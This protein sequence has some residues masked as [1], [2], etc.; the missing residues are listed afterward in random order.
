MT[1][2]LLEARSLNCQYFIY[3]YVDES[4]KEIGSWWVLY[5]NKFL[6]GIRCGVLQGKEGRN[7]EEAG[8]FFMA[9]NPHDLELAG[10]IY[11]HGRGR[12]DKEP[13]QPRLEGL[14]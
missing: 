3:A 7:V 8:S 10:C 6:E 1:G 2:G 12:V 14:S 4:K 13:Q 11:R 9:F 5:P